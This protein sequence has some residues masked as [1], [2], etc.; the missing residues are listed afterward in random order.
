MFQIFTKYYVYKM[1]LLPVP[2]GSGCDDKSGE[3]GVQEDI[4]ESACVL[5][6]LGRKE[7]SFVIVAISNIVRVFS[8][9]WIFS[10]FLSFP[11]KLLCLGDWFYFLFLFFWFSDVSLNLKWDSS[12]VNLGG[13]IPNKSLHAKPTWLIQDIKI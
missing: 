8:R 4:Y 9:L 12:V 13:Q 3:K 5:G 10:Y 11:C 2:R 1:I 6:S 7:R